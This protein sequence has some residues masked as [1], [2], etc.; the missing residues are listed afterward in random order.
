MK[1][2]GYSKISGI[3]AYLPNQSVT[4]QEL[5]HEIKSK[6][7]GVP[8]TFLERACGIFSRRLSTE[9]ESFSYLAVE[10]S[11]KAMQDAQIAPEDIDMILF[12]GI[13]RD[14]PEPSTAHEIQKQIGA[15]N[16]ECLDVSNA[17]IGMLNGFSVAN[18]YIGIGAAEHILVCTGESLPT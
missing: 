14:R 10:A 4:S 5:M 15:I 7:F 13:D 16:A 6:K 8:E 12:C 3:G 1:N 11:I 18:A 2:L 17:C 9:L